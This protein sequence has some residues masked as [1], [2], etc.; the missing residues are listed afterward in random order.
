MYG[1]WGWSLSSIT[2]TKTKMLHVLLHKGVRRQGAN[3]QSATDG[4][5]ADV[6]QRAGEV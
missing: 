6:V 5:M 4:D 1:V 2:M 3:R